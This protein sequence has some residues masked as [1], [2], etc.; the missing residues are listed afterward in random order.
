MSATKKA[1]VLETVVLT[2][3]LPEYGVKSG[4]KAVILE[5][6]EKPEEAYMLEF[7]D[8]TGTSSRIADWVKPDQIKSAKLVAKDF[9]DQGF[10]LLHQGNLSGAEKAFGHAISLYPKGISNIG[11]SIRRSF[12]GAKD[13]QDWLGAVRLYEMCF[14]LAPTNEITR[15]NLAV[16]YHNY[17]RRLMEMGKSDEAL[18]AFHQAIL[19]TSKPAVSEE[20]R[21][22]VAATFTQLGIL[23]IEHQD[24]STAL[25]NFKWA[26]NAHPD[27]ITKSNLAKAYFNLAEACLSEDK[28]TEAIGLFEEALLAGYLEPALYNDYALALAGVGRMEDAIS[29]LEKARALAPDSETIRENL[30]MARVTVDSFR[31]EEYQLQFEPILPQAESVP[32][33]EYQVAA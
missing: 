18:H 31:R 2:E 26:L 27:E 32:T 10:K 21:K 7:V 20:V 25:T 22:S 24:F 8:E 17:G 5:V 15:H 16:A 33:Q 30:Q 12:A 9:L 29:A 11:E 4:E 1:Q 23:A 6:F 3:D 19:A 14:R 28:L 13:E